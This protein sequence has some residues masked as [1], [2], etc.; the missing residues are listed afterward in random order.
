QERCPSLQCQRTGPHTLILCVRGGS[1]RPLC[2]FA[3]NVLSQLDESGDMTAERIAQATRWRRHLHQIPGTEF[4]VG[5]TADFVARTCTDLGW[6][7]TT[8]IGIIETPM[9][10]RFSG[11]TPEGRARVIAQEPV[12]RMGRPEEIASAALWLCSDLGGFAV[13]HA[14]VVDG[15]QTVGIS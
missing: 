9:M 7:V 3:L 15:G 12:G 8:G 4:D 1:D 10:G 6:E 14:L 2:Q 13:S 11:G 5:E